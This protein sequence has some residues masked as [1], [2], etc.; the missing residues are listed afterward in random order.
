MT[1]SSV[2]AMS[3]PCRM[4]VRKLLTFVVVA[5]RTIV[6]HAVRHGIAA[7]QNVH[8]E[9]PQ[10]QAQFFRF[11]VQM[12]FNIH[13]SSSSSQ[14]NAQHMPLGAASG[15]LQAAQSLGSFGAPT[16]NLQNAISGRTTA[17]TDRLYSAT[18]TTGVSTS[19]SGGQSAP[20]STYG[21]QQPNP[22]ASTASTD[23]IMNQSQQYETPRRTRHPD[24]L[25]LTAG[26]TNIASQRGPLSPRDYTPAGPRISLEQA[27]PDTSQYQSAAQLPGS[28][29]PGRPA[30]M[31]ANTAP[32]VPTV[33]QTM[34]QEHYTTPSRSSTLG[35]SH[36][37]TRSSPAAGF[38]G[39]GY[40]P[41]TAA[42][43]GNAD[44]GNFAS[45]T[46]QKYTPQN[47]QRTV[48]NTP[49]G[50]ADIRP[51]A[52][53]GLSDGLPGAN[54]YSYDGANAVPTN[55]NYLAPWAIYAFDWCKWPAQ[56]H[57]AGK[58]ALGS[59]LEDGH[60]FVSSSSSYHI[61]FRAANYFFLPLDTNSRFADH[62]NTRGILH[63]RRSQIRVG[64]CQD[65]RS[66]TLVSSHT[67][68]M[69]TTIFSETIYRST[70]YFWGSSQT[71][72]STFRNTNDH[73]WKF[74]YSI[75]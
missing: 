63:S 27:T 2:T 30:P 52:D 20:P 9:R 47:S 33:P 21:L 48:S 17:G 64:F 36:N 56:N 7:N 1:L 22:I 10:P 71:V 62:T 42:T 65:C 74:H 28:L 51:R 72:V 45:P 39:Q 66:N 75:I 46:S 11:G 31:S 59:Y 58:V 44:Q 73:S 26:T 38:D 57:D 24:E 16:G 5:C 25:H 15:V 4:L 13:S 12:P 70:C 40:A 29:Q 54:P 32:T 8:Q 61:I 37:Y 67:P 18:G 55:S 68:F 6:P 49:L 53:S 3:Q 14:H 35:L 41:F 34:N 60:N 23:T 43:P 69:G 50:L 19:V